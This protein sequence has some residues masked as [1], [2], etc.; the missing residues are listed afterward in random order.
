MAVALLALF[1][2]LTGLAYAATGGNFILGRANSANKT[3]ALTG[4]PTSGAALSVTNATS[5]QPAAAFHTTGTAQPFSVN[6]T[7]KVTNLDADLLD[8]L[9]S[10]AFQ[11]TSDIVRM[12]AVIN[13]GATQSWSIGPYLTLYATCS[14]DSSGNRTFTEQL[15]NNSPVSGQWESGELTNTAPLNPGV[16]ELHAGAASSGL[17]TQIGKQENPSMSSLIGPDGVETVFWRD[18]T[19]EVVTA[20]YSAIAFTNYC[21]IVGTLTRAT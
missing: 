2:N 7:T 20:S 19:G 1:L 8:G 21:E 18:D 6:S 13:F 4:S 9:D 17:E 10:T 11:R 5:G 16:T 12:D 15:L 3:T 14:Q